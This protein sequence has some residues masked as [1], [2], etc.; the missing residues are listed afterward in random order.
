MHSKIIPAIM[1][2]IK[3]RLFD[4]YCKWIFSCIA[5]SFVSFLYRWIILT[6]FL[7]PGFHVFF[8]LKT[9]STN[10]W[11]ISR[12][13]QSNNVIISLHYTIPF[14]VFRMTLGNITKSLTEI[15]LWIFK[16]TWR[17][18]Y[19]VPANHF[20]IKTR[21]DRYRMLFLL[22]KNDIKVKTIVQIRVVTEGRGMCV[23]FCI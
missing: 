17:C 18:K 3:L 19:F 12:E 7:S 10:S 21:K 1:W 15:I 22:M 4:K 14:F 5:C 11:L 13:R 23:H 9:Q 16:H 2:N 20:I 8:S 6:N